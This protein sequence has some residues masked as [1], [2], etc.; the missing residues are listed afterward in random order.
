MLEIISE[1]NNLRLGNM[2]SRCNYYLNIL[3]LF[4]FFEYGNLFRG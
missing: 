2:E 1:V 4:F 3:C